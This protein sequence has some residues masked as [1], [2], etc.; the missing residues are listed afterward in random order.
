MSG[1]HK[2]GSSN[3]FI[4]QKKQAKQKPKLN[5]LQQILEQLENEE[6]VPID[7][8][9]PVFHFSFE[10]VGA[11]LKRLDEKF[12]FTR[13]GDGELLMM[14]G[15]NGKRT[16]HFASNELRK[17]LAET[18]QINDSNYLI[19]NSAFLSD[20]KFVK[21]GLFKRFN[22]IKHLEKISFKY[23]GTNIFYNPIALHYLFVF[24]PE[25][26][27]GF[28]E[29]LQEKKIGLVGS[30]VSEQTREFLGVEEYVEI[31]YT[32]AYAT[33]DKWYP[34]I[35]KMKADLV[36]F[37]AGISS[38][39]AQKRLW[40]NTEKSSIDIGSIVDGLNSALDPEFESGTTRTWVKMALETLRENYK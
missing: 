40:N 38:N 12:C 2:I 10:T 7:S 11:I 6:F 36:L 39:P 16:N 19:G 33:I 34:E 26:F 3:K 24:F 22:T 30:N 14:A 21:K 32:Q 20:E 5:A 18:F 23:A 29:S 27:K 35:I 37:C 28:I 25:I 31:P 13:F 15:W 1:Y 8:T 9:S 17:E 4:Q